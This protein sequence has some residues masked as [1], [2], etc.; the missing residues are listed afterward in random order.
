MS[1]RLRAG[2]LVE[3]RTKEE[4]L[5]TLDGHGQLKGL[6]FMPEM[7]R[8]CG[9]RLRVVKRA[10][11]TCDTVNSTGGRW[12]G[13]A[14]HLEGARCD[15]EHHGGCQAECLI[16]WWEDWL[17]RVPENGEGALPAGPGETAEQGS[18]RQGP[19][20]E[21]E[22]LAG[23]L[24]PD[25]LPAAEPVYVCQATQLP[26]ATKLLRWWDPRQYLEDYLSGNV[27]L[28][29]MFCG[30]IY[31]VSYRLCE[32]RIGYRLRFRALYDRF[33]KLRGGVL[34]PRK[35]G[36][37]PL[38]EK[39]PSCTLDLKV[40]ELV[41]V[42][43]YDEILATVNIHNKNRGMFFDAEMVPF[44][45]GTYRVL[46]RVGRIVDEKTGKMNNFKSE[47][48]MLENVCCRS[49][50]SDRR[51]FCPRAIY[52]LWKEIWLERVP[53]PPADPTSKE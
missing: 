20:S 4:I 18:S 49:R 8:Y 40:G 26:R 45:G 32:S 43:S 44:C 14:V 2:D 41:K 38:S 42:K 17:K 9:K 50:Y 1:K 33:Q 22:L 13:N 39:T 53:S 25:A 29:S 28:W 24:I 51:M 12:L 16:F 30:F 10:H 31:A 23:A 37:I 19:C 35:S 27:G 15:G 47:A 34:F 52:S 5:A 11:K 46:K 48:I 36:K 7:L 6:P 3:V 21:R